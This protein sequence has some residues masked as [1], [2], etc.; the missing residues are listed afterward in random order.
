MHTAAPTIER[1]GSRPIALARPVE[2]PLSLDPAP[3]PVVPPA[4]PPASSRRSSGSWLRSL[5]SR[6]FKPLMTSDFASRYA[7]NAQLIR[8]HWVPPVRRGESRQTSILMQDLG[9][10]HVTCSALSAD[11]QWL[12]YGTDS[13][14]RELICASIF[15]GELHVLGVAAAEQAPVKALA[16]SGDSVCLAAA[17]GRELLVFALPRKEVAARLRVDDGGAEIVACACAE[18]HADTRRLVAACDAAGA[19]TLWRLP[20]A[21]SLQGGAAHTPPPTHRFD[22][23]GGGSVGGGC[24]FVGTECL[25]VG[26]S[27]GLKVWAALDGGGEAE[28]VPVEVE[29]GPGWMTMEANSYGEAKTRAIISNCAPC[30]A[31]QR[32]L[33]GDATAARVWEADTGRLQLTLRSPSGGV[34]AAEFG[35][36][37][38]W[39]I[40]LSGRG[41]CHVFDGSPPA[42]GKRHE[43]R[44]PLGEPELPEELEFGRVHT[45]RLS[46]DEGW[47]VYHCTSN[48]NRG[49]LIVRQLKLPAEPSKATPATF[50]YFRL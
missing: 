11:G 48:L 22:A 6:R 15:S 9:F 21:A 39:L 45:A 32:L 2:V 28:S 14:C 30:F 16:I 35:P 49:A 42:D 37:G 25:A 29:Q 1:K 20:E 7:T 13:G 47:L 43:E 46:P 8:P 3:A 10:G 50:Q 33:A 36:S 31:T 44:E 40:T 19:T 4:P 38:R 23:A 41:H 24:A 34:R 26:G 17:R 18:R 5:T 27:G 12:A